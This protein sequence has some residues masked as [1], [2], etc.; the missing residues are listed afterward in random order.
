MNKQCIRCSKTFNV[1]QWDLDFYKK[2]TVPEPTYCPECRQQRRLASANQLYLYKNTCAATGKSIISN[3]HPDDGFIVYDQAYWHS[4]QWNPLDYGVDFDFSRPFFDQYYD[5]AKRIPRP[6][7]LNG[8]EYDENS[9]YTNHSARNKNCHMI[10]DSDGNESCYYGYGVNTCKQCLDCYRVRKSE[11]CYECVDCEDCY[12]CW[13]VQDC[14]GCTQSVLLKDCIDVRNSILCVGLRH[15]EYHILNKPV[16]PEEY[17]TTLKKLQSRQGIV[18]LQKQFA[19]FTLKFP[20]KYIHGNHNENV[21]GDYV[22]NCKQTLDCYDCNDLENAKYFCQAFDSAKDCMD[23]Q[24]VG[25]KAELVYE[26]ST[27]GYTVYNVQFSYNGLGNLVNFM[28]CQYCFKSQDLFGCFGL[29]NKQFCI[30]NKQYSESDYHTL[31]AKIIAHMKQTGEYGEFWP[32]RYAWFA[33]NESLAQ[34]YFPLTKDQVLGQHLHWRDPVVSPAPNDDE[35]LLTC[36]TCTKQFKL[37]AQEVAIYHVAQIPLP[38]QCFTCR[39]RARIA[40]RN[41]RSLWHRQCMC[42]QTD[43]DHQGLC[44]TEFDTTYAPERKEIVYCEKCYQKE[45]Y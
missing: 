37:I 10:F 16:S 44:N 24:E 45:I 36:S 39:H 3:Y 40:Q 26:S 30:L 4:D 35:T 33:Y 5:F 41:P 25:D 28:Y 14:K 11:L 6:N 2:V 32:M 19:D 31:R 12:A 42:T 29:R 21:T 22:N 20:N 8:Y 34:D 9:P 38:D 18:E 17:K 7:L 15:K 1:N 43:H 27:I 13:Y 23:C